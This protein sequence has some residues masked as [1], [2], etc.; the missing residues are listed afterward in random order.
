MRRLLLASS[1]VVLTATGLPS[2]SYAQQ[3]INLHLGGFVP[4][5]L[6][7]RSADDALVN[8]LLN[9]E[10]SLDFD[11]KDFAGFSIG[12][13]WLFGLH[14]RV[15]AGLGIGYYSRSVD[16]VYAEFIEDN[17]TEIEQDLRLRVAPFTATIRFLPVG[18]EAA[19]QPYIGGGVGVFGW[20]Y[21]EIGEFVDSF[22]DSVF[23]GRFIESGAAA[24]PVILGGVRFPLGSW[25]LGGEIR[26]QNASGDLEKEGF[27]GTTI[28][29]DGFSY[30]M[31]F[32]IRF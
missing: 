13:E 23:Q 7:G 29:L 19:I 1:L 25:D 20:R 8:N 30:L 18:R 5:G 11:I 6:S 24:G 10:Y 12:G 32:N 21:S 3:S 9:G 2:P 26:Y 22:D 28:D 31:T 15:E 16:S 4:S 14:P 17:G 27:T